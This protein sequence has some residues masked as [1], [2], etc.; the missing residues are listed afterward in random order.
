M[1]LVQLDVVG[2]QK[3]AYLADNA[4]IC[5]VEWKTMRQSSVNIRAMHCAATPFGGD[6]LK[7]SS[8]IRF[9]PLE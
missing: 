6:C 7:S 5:G 1:E 2:K 4:D 8:C 9:E 3:F